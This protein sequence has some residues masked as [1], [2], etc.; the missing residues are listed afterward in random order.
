MIN[1][2]RRYEL[3]AEATSSF[4]RG[5]GGVEL[6]AEDVARIDEQRRRDEVEIAD[7]ATHYVLMGLR[8]LASIDPREVTRD[9]LAGAIAADL[10]RRFA[11]SQRRR[12]SADDVLAVEQALA[13][14]DDPEWRQDGSEE[15]ARFALELAA[16][17]RTA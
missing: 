14:G 7:P 8:L 15:Y 11:P 1:E 4:W 6:T 10:D 12:W 9:E 13:S 17:A 16:R 5:L 2:Q 3:V